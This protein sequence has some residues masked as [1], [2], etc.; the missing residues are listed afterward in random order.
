MLHPYILAKKH[1]DWI[2]D[3]ELH[4]YLIITKYQKYINFRKGFVRYSEQNPTFFEERVSKI[5]D[6]G[7]LESKMFREH[8]YICLFIYYAS[9]LFLCMLKVGKCNLNRSTFV[10]LENLQEQA[11]DDETFPLQQ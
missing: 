7:V 4:V 11:T 1:P 10:Y 8:S 2:M 6:R 3:T 5:E 9:F